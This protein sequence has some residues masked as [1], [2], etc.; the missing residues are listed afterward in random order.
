MKMFKT[1]RCW[2]NDFAFD[3]FIKN[4][5]SKSKSVWLREKKVYICHGIMYYIK[6]INSY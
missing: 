3:F 1:G 4:K 2:N 6:H 5:K